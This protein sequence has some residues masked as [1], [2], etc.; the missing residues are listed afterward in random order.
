M[1]STSL[2]LKPLRL[3]DSLCLVLW[4]PPQLQNV[5]HEVASVHILHDKEQVLPGME[6]RVEAGEK[7][8]LLLH[9]QHP[10]LVEGTLHVILLHYQ[11]LLQTLDGIH[12]LGS[13]VFCQKY[14]KEKC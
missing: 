5:E 2:P 13:L 3:I 14:L 10:P 7:W 8:R 11:V 1:K 6:A 4:E 12:I 9:G